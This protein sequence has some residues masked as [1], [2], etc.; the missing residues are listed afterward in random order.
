MFLELNKIHE[1][2]FDYSLMIPWLS[3][4]TE[5]AD[6]QVLFVDFLPSKL[7]NENYLMLSQAF[8]PKEFIWFQ[9]HLI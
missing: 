6:I 7:V 5:T 4:I 9:R 1:E 2:L 3:H 8:F